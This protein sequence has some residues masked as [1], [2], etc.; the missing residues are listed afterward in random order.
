MGR[1]NSIVDNDVTGAPAL[2]GLAADS[3]VQIVGNRV[4]L[5]QSPDT[6]HRPVAAIQITRHRDALIAGNTVSSPTRGILALADD[7]PRNT[8]VERNRVTRTP[9]PSD[10]TAGIDVERSSCRAQERRDRASS[11]ASS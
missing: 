2:L 11:T 8:V 5:P 7:G 3:N 1:D 10:I 4:S 9:S 6:T